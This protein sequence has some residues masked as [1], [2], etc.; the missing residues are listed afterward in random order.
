M[1]Q[2]AVHL[3]KKKMNVHGVELEEKDE[4]ENVDVPVVCHT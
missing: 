2:G 4:E 3:R 1:G